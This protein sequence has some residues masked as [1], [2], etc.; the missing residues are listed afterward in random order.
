M[1]QMASAIVSFAAK[2]RNFGHDDV[3]RYVAENLGRFFYR[4]RIWVA[5]DDIT[6]GRITVRASLTS[7][8][9]GLLKMDGKDARKLA[10]AI[11]LI[12]YQLPL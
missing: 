12:L 5:L 11:S 8:R 6:N 7:F 4:W 10:D 9:D 2:E 3:Y 1:K